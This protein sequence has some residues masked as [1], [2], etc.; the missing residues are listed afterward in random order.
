MQAGGSMTEK[1]FIWGIIII[2]GAWRVAETVLP[3]RSKV[4]GTITSKWLFY[5]MMSSGAVIYLLAILEFIFRVKQL[6]YT[7]TIIGCALIIV[8]IF[9]KLWALRSLDKLWSINIEIREGHK[10]I[11]SGPYK[12]IRHP[13][14][15]STLTEVLSGPLILN[16][17]FTLIYV[18]IFYIPLIFIRINLEEKELENKFGDEYREYKKKVPLLLPFRMPGR[19]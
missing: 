5:C 15:L 8:R 14:Y 18:A 1:I 17:Y 16:A 10:L 7:V 9:L 11:T 13:S 19:K 12:Y 6:N 3:D 4:K 2:F